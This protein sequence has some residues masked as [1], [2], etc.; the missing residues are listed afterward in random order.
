MRLAG[1]E[2]RAD[3]AVCAAAWSSAAIELGPRTFQCPGELWQCAEAL[4]NKRRWAGSV[5]TAG[6]YR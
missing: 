3:A 2:K 6:V 1:R 4:F 5:I